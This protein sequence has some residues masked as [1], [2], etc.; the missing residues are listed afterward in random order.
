METLEVQL[1]KRQN[2]FQN[3]PRLKNF[4][5]ELRSNQ[6]EA[7]KLLWQ[8]IRAKQ[9]K[10]YKFIR[11]FSIS[12]YILDFYCAETKLGIELDGGGHA[13]PET[14]L[15]DLEKENYLKAFGIKVLRFWN[16]D[17][18]TNLDSVLNEIAQNLP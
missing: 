7:E 3:N 10:G 16:T 14:T 6:T 12:H 2:R 13:S 4:R 11:Q 1:W 17:I 8:K 15:K 18:Y 9:I 5:R